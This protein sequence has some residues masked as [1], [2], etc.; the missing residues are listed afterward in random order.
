MGFEELVAEGA[1][2]PLEG[3]DFSWF[4]GRATEERPPWGYAGLIAERLARVGTALDL[5][6]GGGE[7]TAFAPVK[8]PVLVAPSRGRRTLP[9]PGGT[10]PAP[11]CCGC[12]TRGRCRSGTPRS[13]SSSAATRS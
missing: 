12:R 7:V 4:D 6:T 11:R 5:Q 13:T 9:W 1:A 3:W 10:C 8:P 2:V